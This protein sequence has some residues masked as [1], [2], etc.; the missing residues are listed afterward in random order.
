MKKTFSLIFLMV[1]PV[2]FSCSG[3]KADKPNPEVVFSTNMGDIV[4]NLDINK[5]PVT[6]ANFIQYVNDGFYDSTIIHRV[7]PRFV[8]QGGGYDSFLKQKP[9]REPIKNV[10][11]NGLSNVR[12]TVAM[13]RS[14]DLNSATSQ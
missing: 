5:S 4:I 2:I 6:V 8:I 14:N 13:A 3:T 11:G 7:V 10:S 1:L 9:T 12:G